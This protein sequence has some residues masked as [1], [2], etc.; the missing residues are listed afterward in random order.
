MIALSESGVRYNNSGFS[1]DGGNQNIL[2]PEDVLNNKSGLCI[3]T[4]LVI[5]SL[6]VN[7]GFS[8]MIILPPGHA[9]VAIETKDGSGQ[10]LLIETTMIPNTREDFE[11]YAGYL[12]NMQKPQGIETSYPVCYLD[13]MDWVEYVYGQD[14]HVINCNDA[15]IYGITPFDN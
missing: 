7:A 9:Q 2:L 1:I 10:Y 15:E 5:A 14:C 6:F 11:E 4:S 3:E 8:T 12:A 13:T